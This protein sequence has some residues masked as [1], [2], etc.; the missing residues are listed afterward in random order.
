MNVTYKL[1]AGAQVN[2]LSQKIYHT[3]PKKP[4]LHK[5]PVAD[6]LSR[7]FIP[8]KQCDAEDEAEY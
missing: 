1:D 2:I 7:S 4:Q 3:L 5:L 8:A 6:T